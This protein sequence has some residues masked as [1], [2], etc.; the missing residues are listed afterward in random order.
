MISVL[1]LVV[2]GHNLAVHFGALASMA[3]LGVNVIGK[4]HGGGSPGQ[5]DDISLGCEDVDLLGEQIGL[6]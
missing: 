5:F 2:Q 6:E 4:I 3:N 1:Q